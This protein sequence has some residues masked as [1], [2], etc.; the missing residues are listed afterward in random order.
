M[1][2]LDRINDFY[3][4]LYK[5][6]FIKT[7]GFELYRFEEYGFFALASS[8]KTHAG[9]EL[10]VSFNIHDNFPD[11]VELVIQCMN[12]TTLEQLHIIGTKVCEELKRDMSLYQEPGCISMVSYFDIEDITG[13]M[14]MFK[15][16]LEEIG[17]VS[18]FMMY[19]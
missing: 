15:T 12:Q 10:T 6:D 19:I 4:E 1:S 8:L 17:K 18:V 7:R 16:L 5:Y 11:Q 3:Q 2:S 14:Q 13:I 9:R